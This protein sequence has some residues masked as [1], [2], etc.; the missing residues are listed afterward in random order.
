M[1]GVNMVGSDGA[2]SYNYLLSL[3]APLSST[4]AMA[5]ICLSQNPLTSVCQQQ[6]NAPTNVFDL[7]S[8]S[9]QSKGV[10]GWIDMGLPVVGVQYVIEGAQQCWAQGGAATEWITTL[11]FFCGRNQDTQWKVTEPSS[12]YHNISIRT[13]LACPGEKSPLTK[14]LLKEM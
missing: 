14:I 4:S 7:G 10:W 8:W 1:T 3:C 2:S 9:A 5:T 6:S 11:Q 12:C 13:P